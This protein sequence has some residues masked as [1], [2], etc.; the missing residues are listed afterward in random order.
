MDTTKQLDTLTALWS[1]RQEMD[2]REFQA[3]KRAR[4]AGA[5]WE[6]IGDAMGVSRQ[7]VHERYTRLG[8]R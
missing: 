5:S 4:L 3:V 6:T 1:E 7:A 8:V 2:E